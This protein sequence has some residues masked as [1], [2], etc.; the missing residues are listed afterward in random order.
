MTPTEAKQYLENVATEFLKVFKSEDQADVIAFA[1]HFVNTYGDLEVPENWNLDD[2]D[3]YYSPGRLMSGIYRAVATRDGAALARALDSNYDFKRFAGVYEPGASRWVKTANSNDIVFK[4]KNAGGQECRVTAKGSGAESS[5]TVNG[6]TATV[7]EIV[8]LTAVEGSTTHL[9]ATV[10]TKFSERAHTASNSVSAKIANIEVI[11]A[12]NATDTRITSNVE[13]KV[14]GRSVVKA[15]AVVDGHDLCNR[16]KIERLINDEDGDG[17]ANLM[18]KATAETDVLGSLQVKGEV[19]EI[20]AVVDALDGC[21]DKYEYSSKEAA[22]AACEKDCGVLNAN[23]VSR[24]YYTTELLQ[25]QIRF[26]PKLEEEEYSDWSWWEW[27]ASPVLYFLADG[28]TYGFEEYFGNSRFISVENQWEA[29]VE[30]YKRLW[31]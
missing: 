22:R 6:T 9:S 10:R 24:I 3:Y 5:A 4:F 30:S 29:L 17:L 15:T 16:D 31:K 12:M 1:N 28:S 25:A 20:K 2:E 14:S 26:Q 27:Q 13:V 19:S 23:V 21:Y 11:S 18:T 8:T 7:P